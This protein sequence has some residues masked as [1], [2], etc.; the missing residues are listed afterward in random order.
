MILNKNKIYQEYSIFLTLVV[1]F[2]PMFLQYSLFV[3]FLL[4]PEF[5]FLI[6]I[7]SSFFLRVKFNSKHLLL[8]LFIYLYIVVISF[9]RF[10]NENYMNIFLTMTT[11]GRLLLYLCFVVIFSNLFKRDFAAKLIVFVALFNSLYGLIQFYSHNFLG[12]TLPWYLP[13][14]N[15]EHG[16]KLITDQDY[17]F[18][19]FGFRFSGLFSE[20]AHFSQFVGFAFLVLIFYSNGKFFNKSKKILISI[21][22]SMSLLLSASGTGFFVIMFLIGAYTYSYIFNYFS[23]KKLL[24]GLFG[25][26]FIFSLF[27]YSL[28]NSDIFSFGV[29]RILS[30]EDNSSLYVRVVRPLVIFLDLDFS[31]KLF[32]VGYGNYSTFLESMD[33]FNSYEKSLGFAW[34]NSFGVFLVGSGIFGVVLISLFYLVTHLKTDRFGRLVVTF[35]IFHFFFSDLP[36]TIFFICFILFATSSRNRFMC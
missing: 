10:F 18:E 36:H 21:I 14:L 4:F 26:S 17:I 29:S 5:F 15:V 12:L 1:V 24:I 9:F 16:K 11:S 13:F 25:F 7:L 34:T 35:V 30:L 8:V 22:F 3:P 6:F 19:A 23:F 31:Q 2:S 20:P 28:L 27:V 32:G 33:Y